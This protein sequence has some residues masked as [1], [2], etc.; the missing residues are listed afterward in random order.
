MSIFQPGDATGA[1]PVTGVL[2]PATT[3]DLRRG[4]FPFRSGTLC[5][6][7]VATLA[8]RG[9]GDRELLSGPAEFATWL[10]AAELP[11]VVEPVSVV[12]VLRVIE[13]REA[14]HELTRAR[15]DERQLPRK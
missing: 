15:V 7:F 6:D 14:I 13:L 1:V 9:M 10:R 12:D 2:V 4:G 8:K 11:G 5:L 3:K